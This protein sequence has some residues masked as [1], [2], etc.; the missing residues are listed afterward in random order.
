MPFVK[1]PAV[2]F[3]ECNFPFETQISEKVFENSF[4]G[5]SVREMSPK[6]LVLQRQL[7][8]PSQDVRFGSPT[9]ILSGLAFKQ[10]RKMVSVGLRKVALGRWAFW[11]PVFR[12]RPNRLLVSRSD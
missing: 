12:T 7:N 3:F 4:Q 6:N 2:I 9:F 10:N 5:S 1:N 11:F 8:T